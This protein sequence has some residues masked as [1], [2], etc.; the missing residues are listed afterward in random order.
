[1]LTKEVANKIMKIEGK[2]RGVGF[3]TDAIYIRKKKGEVGL[4]E[5]KNQLK[6]LGYP[7]KYEEIKALEWHSE[8]LR[9]FSLL[10]VKDL[11]NW[12][13]KDFKAMGDTA[14]IYSFLVKLMMKFFIALKMTFSNAPKYW[15]MHHSEGKLEIG[16][17]NIER[18]YAIIY[19]KDFK[20]HPIYCNYLEGYFRRLVQFSLPKEK[21]EA[22]E[23]KCAFKGNPYHE[24]RIYW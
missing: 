1:M 7:I 11:F 2:V 16:E 14:P 19:L 4:N 24:Y 5:V 22:K 20:T 23:I 8:G 18:K 13:T 3:Q 17:V 21:V 12:N 10:V 15:R 6:N 9:I